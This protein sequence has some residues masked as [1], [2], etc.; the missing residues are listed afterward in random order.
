MGNVSWRLVKWVACDARFSPNQA[1][2]VSHPACKASRELIFHQNPVWSISQLSCEVYFSLLK[3]DNDGET[4]SILMPGFCF[5]VIPTS[6]FFLHAVFSS[7]CRLDCCT[8]RDSYSIRRVA[9]W[10]K[11][12]FIVITTYVRKARE[13]RGEWVFAKSMK[14][15]EH[16][17]KLQKGNADPTAR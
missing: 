2:E 9:W 12:W 5:W 3:Y 15:D 16:I 10:G 1:I 8:Y 13:A 17:K 11:V 4:I 6:F 14:I 7:C